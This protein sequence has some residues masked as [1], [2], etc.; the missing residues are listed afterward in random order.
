MPGKGRGLG[1]PHLNRALETWNVT[2]L[3]QCGEC[4]RL[5]NTKLDIIRLNT[6]HI[7]GKNKL[8]YD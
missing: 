2:L 3:T 8:L 5:N 4:V 1:V 6:M 7:L